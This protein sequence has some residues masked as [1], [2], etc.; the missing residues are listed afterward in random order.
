MGKKEFEIELEKQFGIKL[1]DLQCPK[2]GHEMIIC[3]HCGHATCPME[4]PERELK[5][6][7]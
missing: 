3:S 4:C 6:N 5:K 1:E 7:R 2:C